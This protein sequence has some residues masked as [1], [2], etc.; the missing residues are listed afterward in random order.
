MA[1]LYSEPNTTVML[2][3][4]PEAI[5][6]ISVQHRQLTIYRVGQKTDCL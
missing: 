1:K 4:W 2:L 5:T 6:N 3:R